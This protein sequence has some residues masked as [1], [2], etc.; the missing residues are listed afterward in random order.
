MSQQPQAEFPYQDSGLVVP[1][2]LPGDD[3]LTSLNKAMAF[4]TTTFTSRFPSTNNQLR[5]S[6]NPRNQAT[7]QDGR[8]IVQQ[9]QGRQGQSFA[10]MRSKSNA[11]SSVINRNRGIMQQFKQGWSG[12]TIVK[13]K[14]IWQEAGQTDDLDAFNSNCD[15][16]P[17]AKAFLMANLSSYDSTVISEMYYS[18]QPTFDPASDIEIT[19]DSNIISYH[20]YLKET[21]SETVQNTASTEQQNVVIMSVFKEIPNLVA[22]CNAESIQ[23]KNVN[24]S[25]TVELERYKERVRMF[26]ERQKVDLN[27]REKY[28]ESQMNDM[29]LNKNANEHFGKYFVPQKELSTEQAFWLPISNPISKQHVVEPTPVKI[30]VP[31]ELPKG[32]EHTKEVFITQVIPF[33]NALRK[34]FKDFDNGLYD[35]INKVKTVFNQMEATVKQC[36]VDKKCF[37]IQ[38]KPLLLEN[39][40]LLELLISQDLVHNVVNSLEVTDECE[41]LKESWLDLE[42]LSHRLKNNREAH[43]GYLQQT[44]EHSDT[45]RVIVE[46]ARKHNPS[47]PYLDYAFPQSKK[48]NWLLSHQRTKPEKLG[49]RHLGVIASTSAS[50]SH[51]K[52]NTK[53]NRITPPAS[54]NQ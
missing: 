6:S 18:E 36:S 41:S 11:T 48:R 12:V 35:E 3:P 37:E 42:P 7:I 25:L 50:G 31:S 30:E 53:K 26:E 4:L 17:C 51:S 20:Q 24:E 52:N 9:V 44:K 45:L 54:S 49:L 29:I 22:K 46:Q 34:S 23:N 15:E 27:D 33:L 2:F 19:S 32:F 40:R 14:G 43:E 28:I 47:D 8:V 13:E 39:D 1:S 10:G 21:E 5:T 38:K 16:A